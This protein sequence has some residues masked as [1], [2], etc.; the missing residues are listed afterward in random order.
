MA[1][2]FPTLETLISRSIE[3]DSPLNLLPPSQ[4]NRRNAVAALPAIQWIEAKI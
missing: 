4:K 2:N 1:V 3:N